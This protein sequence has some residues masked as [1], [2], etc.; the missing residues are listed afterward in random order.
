MP[1]LKSGKG[2][3]R[4][5]HGFHSTQPTILHIR[6][7]SSCQFSCEA[8]CRKQV[9]FLLNAGAMDFIQL[10]NGHTAAKQYGRQTERKR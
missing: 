8:A 10:K 5:S 7:L 1:L 4:H 3:Q 2:N 6:I 9:I